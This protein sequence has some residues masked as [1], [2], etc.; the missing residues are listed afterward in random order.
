MECKPATALRGGD[1]SG[2]PL[3]P[4]RGAAWTAGEPWSLMKGPFQGSVL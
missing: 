4:H 1:L 3:Q 2:R